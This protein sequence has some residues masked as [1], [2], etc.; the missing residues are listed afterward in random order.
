MSSS[1]DAPSIVQTLFLL[2]LLFCFGIQP[3]LAAAS[4]H[5]HGHGHI[6]DHYHLIS[7]RNGSHS[8][9]ASMSL[10]EAQSIVSQ[11]QEAMAAAN[12][13]ILKNPSPNIHQTLNA[14][15]LEQQRE[16]APYLAYGK[17][18]D[19]STMSARR[20]RHRDSLSQTPTTNS[21]SLTYTI[22]PEVVAAARL[23]A[24]ASPPDASPENYAAMIATLKARFAPK[25]NDTNVMPQK[26]RHPS[27]L[28][29]YV[30]SDELPLIIQ[31]GTA[32]TGT[33]SGIYERDTATFWQ[34]TIPQLGESPFAPA[35]YKVWRNVKDYGAK[36]D[37]VTDDT[38]AIQL[39][40]SDGG[41][42]GANCGSSTIYPATVYF[43]SG[44][45]LVSSS[46]TQ[47]FNTEML[48]N[49][50][51]LPTILASPSFVG[52][53]VISSDFYT[54][55]QSEWYLNTNN[56][57]RSIRNFIIDIRA[58]PQAAQVCGV[59]WYVDYSEQP[60]PPKESTYTRPIFSRH[61]PYYRN[62][63]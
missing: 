1:S 23:V 11:F 36:G 37:G 6:H 35:G 2:F 39:A 48:G 33:S 29:G 61:K 27:G 12:A 17:S 60:F 9:N 38:A 16:N 21:S 13:R 14:S 49:P 22:P 43:P 57:L 19:S 58:T 51:D 42:C 30:P 28:V 56:F 59:H 25:L 15:T 10:A 26:L 63:F 45:Y 53:G 5:G 55:A 18:N 54:G 52:L 31:N 3:I 44:T 41:R 62:I 34:E 47:Y 4:H 8:S 24:E 46:I 50:L 20:L 32:V 7:K 40:I